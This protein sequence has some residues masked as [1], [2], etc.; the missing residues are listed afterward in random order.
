MRCNNCGYD[1]PSN[2]MRCDKCN[3]PLH[4]SMVNPN[5]GEL[6]DTSGGLSGTIKGNQVD[7]APWDCPKCGRP[8][9]PGSTACNYCGY[10]FVEEQA[11]REIKY[12]Q[13]QEPKHEQPQVE[14]KE[15][16]FRKKGSDLGKTIGTE[17]GFYLKPIATKYENEMEV[18][19]INAP[20]PEVELGRDNLEKDN[21]TI[22]RSQAVM[23]NKKGKWY[24]KNQSEEKTTYIFAEEFIELQDGDIIMMGNRKFIF[25]T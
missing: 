20:L 3:A 1:N 19:K 22:S 12:E 11:E 21:P 17:L 13:K 2:K 23:V 25:S 6:Q 7:A 5:P 24:I 14:L 15:E 18:V 16:V 8:V 10:K 9:I 4:G